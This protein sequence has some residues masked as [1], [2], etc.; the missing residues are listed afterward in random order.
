MVDQSHM[1]EF[2]EE[3][4]M[5]HVTVRKGREKSKDVLTSLESRLGRVEDIMDRMVVRLEDDV[6]SNE[7]IDSREKA[8]KGKLQGVLNS[9]MDKLRIEFQ[10]QVDDV[11]VAVTSLQEEVKVIKEDVLLCRVAIANGS[12]NVVGKAPRIDAPKPKAFSGKRDAKELDVFPFNMDQYFDHMGIES[13]EMKIKTI[14]LFLSDT[15]TIWWRYFT[16]LDL[17]SGYYQVRIAEGNEAKTTCVTRYGSFEFL[18]MP[19]G[20]T[21][22]PATFC[23]LM[24][25]IFHPYLDKFVVVY[26]DDI[27]VYSA[28]LE[29]HVEYLRIVFKVLASN[30]LYEKK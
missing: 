18:V 24:N 27:V 9:L 23:T 30:E 12:A 10:A 2:G 22:A 14:A 20:L 16:K 15:A 8:F 26:L 1:T 17:R 6:P 7:A 28:T 11:R 13:E 4:D 3:V 5:P 25:N 21:N 19:F 29:E